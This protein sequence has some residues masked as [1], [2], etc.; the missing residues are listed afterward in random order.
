MRVHTGREGD[1]SMPE[2]GFA[3]LGVPAFHTA[4]GIK[5]SHYDLLVMYTDTSHKLVLPDDAESLA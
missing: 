4:D 1:N 5:S 3:V 2:V